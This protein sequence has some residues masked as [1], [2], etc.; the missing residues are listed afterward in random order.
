MSL[1]FQLCPSPG[2]LMVR[3]GETCKP[4]CLT[5]TLK[6]GGGSAMIWWC[7][8]KAV[9]GQVCLR[10]GCINQATT[11]ED[12]LGENLLPSALTMFP[13]S[14]DCFFF[15]GRTMT[16]HTVRS[17]KHHIN[18]ILGVDGRRPV[19]SP[20]DNLWSVIKSKMGGHKPSNK[21]ELFECLWHEVTQH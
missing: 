12:I 19:P 9:I 21:A 6:F 15:F 17:I 2:R 5:P 16:C 20:M 1:V 10:E 11:Y 14:E 8:S 18:I 4:Q 7:F 3:P 13:N